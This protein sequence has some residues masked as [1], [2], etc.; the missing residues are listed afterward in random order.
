MHSVL[1][2]DSDVGATKLHFPPRLRSR[3]LHSR[4]LLRLA[5]PKLRKTIVDANTLGRCA[6]ETERPHTDVRLARAVVH[7]AAPAILGPPLGM[8]H[9]AAQEVGLALVSELPLLALRG[10]PPGPLRKTCQLGSLA[11]PAALAIQLVLSPVWPWHD[12]RKRDCSLRALGQS[13]Q[14]ATQHAPCASMTN[15]GL[16][17]GWRQYARML[18]INVATQEQ[19]N[20]LVA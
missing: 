16:S 10:C 6:R 20:M 17:R 15:S 1:V 2:K 12:E 8:A 7:V 11:G 9:H 3:A 13:W 18:T 4:S 5:A 14:H 19:I